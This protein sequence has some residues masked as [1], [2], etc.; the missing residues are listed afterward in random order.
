[1]KL[2]YQNLDDIALKTGLYIK[3]PENMTLY[4]K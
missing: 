1:M 2:W 3:K 4:L